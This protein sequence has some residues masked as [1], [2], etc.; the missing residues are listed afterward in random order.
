MRSEGAALATA[1]DEGDAVFEYRQIHEDL[2]RLRQS[3]AVAEAS[4]SAETAAAD[5][6]RVH[7]LE[8][9]RGTEDTMWQLRINAARRA[10][11]A[12]HV[13]DSTT[14]CLIG[15]AAAPMRCF[16]ALLLANF[17][18]CQAIVSQNDNSSTMQA[19]LLDG[20]DPQVRA[21][22][23]RGPLTAPTCPDVEK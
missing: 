20:S 8:V 4:L 17:Q 13:W 7:V 14:C 19:L 6:F 23:S 11:A 22:T 15:L 1:M 5:G 9:V 3:I 18:L 2:Q 21:S 12:A 16:L 10:V